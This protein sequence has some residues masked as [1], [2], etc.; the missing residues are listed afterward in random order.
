MATERPET[1]LILAANPIDQPPLRLDQEVREIKN[2]LRNSRKHF[3]LEQQW[4]VR[5]KDL[6]RALLDH[7]PTYVHFCGHGA[8][9]AGIVLEGQLVDADALAGLFALF[10]GH[11]K[12]VVL[13]ACYS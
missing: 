6:R 2:G 4:A 8:G 7:N 10:S 13:N 9:A 3:E 5:P 11:V 12:C 1:I